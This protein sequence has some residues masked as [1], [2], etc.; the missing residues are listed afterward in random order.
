MPGQSPTI[1]T[2]L[3]GAA[4][5]AVTRR[6]VAVRFGRPCSWT[7]PCRPR[8]SGCSA[9]TWE[10]ITASS[11]LWR[12]TG[13]GVRPG[14]ATAGSHHW[15]GVSGSAGKACGVA[16]VFGS[17]SA[18]GPPRLQCLRE[19]PGRRAGYA[20]RR[21]PP[22]SGARHRSAGRRCAWPRPACPPRSIPGRSAGLGPLRRRQAAAPAGVV[23]R[24]SSA[25]TAAG[26]AGGRPP[27]GGPRRTGTSMHEVPQERQRAAPDRGRPVT[28]RR[29]CLA[30]TW[31]R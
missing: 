3:A 6:P 10:S 11:G 20:G 1:P 2:P 29:C 19:R 8:S 18:S 22:A 7:G 12:P 16:R 5:T 4:A 15:S 23:D 21:P 27:G 24:G 17:A 26:R 9:S 13:G 14:S 25:A 28:R 31:R 30:T